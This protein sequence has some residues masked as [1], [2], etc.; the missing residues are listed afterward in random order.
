MRRRGFITG[1]LPGARIWTIIFFIYLY[2]PM[3]VLVFYSFNKGR[4][5]QIW[6]G[7]GLRWYV[8]AFANDDIQRAALNSLIV[9]TIATVFAVIFATLAALVLGRR[10]HFRGKVV[11]IG[12][13]S[14]PLVVPEIATAVA[15]L[16]FFSVV[17]I[18]LGLSTIIIAH[19]VFCIPF[20]FLTNSGAPRRHG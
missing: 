15:T 18:S 19:T 7:F 1:E 6:E 13:I 8:R 9:A 10:Q 14:L 12:L 3:L 5:G 2:A 17:K 20:A 11:S 16:C 4:L